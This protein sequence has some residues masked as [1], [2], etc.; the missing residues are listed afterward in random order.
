MDVTT[1]LIFRSYPEYDD[2]QAD[3]MDNEAY[4]NRF[5]AIASK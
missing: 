2:F 4:I 5:D 1:I 3:L